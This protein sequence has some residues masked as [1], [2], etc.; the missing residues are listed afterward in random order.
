VKFCTLALQICQYYNVALH[1][2]TKTAVEM[3]APVPEIM[4]TPRINIPSS[5]TYKSCLK[6]SILWFIH[7][8]HT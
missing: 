2:T 8:Q 4:D 3:A 6:I 5:Q 7:S 1:Y